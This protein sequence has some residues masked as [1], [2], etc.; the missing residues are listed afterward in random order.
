M[1]SMVRAE[2][3]LDS[4]LEVAPHGTRTSKQNKS[5]L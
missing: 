1:L 3:V 2:V 4:T 5:K